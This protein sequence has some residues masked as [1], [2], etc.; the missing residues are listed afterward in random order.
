MPIF[1]PCVKSIFPR[2]IDEACRI[3]PQELPPR[4]WQ[5]AEPLVTIGAVYCMER[6]VSAKLLKSGAIVSAMTLVSRVLGL[7]RDVVTANILGAGALAD[8]FL[9]VNRIP[10]FLRRLFAEGAFSQAFVPVLAEVK[11][12]HGDDAVRLLV[13]K[14]AGTLGLIVTGVTMLAMIA[15]PVIMAL[16]GMG[17]FQAYLQGE[18]DG[19]KYLE[20]SALLK[21]TFPYLWFITFV[22]LSGA[23][24][25]TYNRFAVAAFSPVFL[26]I[27]MIGCAIWL[28][29][30]TESAAEALAWGVFLGGLLQFLFQLP[31]LTK[32]G[33]LVR[34]RW[35]WKDPHVIRIRTLMIP[36][37]FGVSVSQINLL[38]DA[39]IASF[40]QD[41]SVSWLYYSDRLLEFPLG[42]FGIAIATVILPNLSR[43]HALDDHRA[44]QGTMDWAILLICVLGLPSMV[45]LAVLAEP[46]LLTVFAHGRFTAADATA[47]AWSL[48][49]YCVGLV[50]LMLIKA[51]APGFYSRQD[52][53]TPVRIGII[54][55]I[56]NM[57][58]NLM[59]APFMSYAGLALATSFSGSLNA[60]LL[61]RGLKQQQIYQLAPHL[62][63]L[64]TKAALAAGGMGA[65]VFWL[66]PSVEAFQQMDLLQR[67]S[68]VGGGIS[69][70]VVVYVAL[71]WGLGIRPMHFRRQSI[72][73]KQM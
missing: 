40:L 44:F 37:L 27:A 13:A 35:G 9:M 8:V 73:E 12:K 28:S 67:G 26:N 38:L 31:F 7:V 69:A 62:R 36:A 41:G 10:N 16:F 64:L 29:P 21:I 11:A 47:S 30:H 53:K 22:A 32:Q 56:A 58:F 20:A 70:A 48:M 4:C 57:A 71:L 55:M 51:L 24:L 23:V 52:V 39:V 60:W 15:S 45:G 50:P 54:A 33:M 6:I 2:H 65:V 61:Y 72:A 19:Q 46:I 34:P 43:H 1:W 14:A 42:M 63:G 66:M 59:L 3:K 68:W 17:W 18:P 25:N 5:S 49:A